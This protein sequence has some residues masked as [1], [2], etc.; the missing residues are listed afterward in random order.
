MGGIHP[1]KAFKKN[2][3]ISFF[4][5]IHSVPHGEDAILPGSFQGE[6]DTSIVGRIFHGIV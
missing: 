1:V 3:Q 5:L 2:I 6:A 4:N